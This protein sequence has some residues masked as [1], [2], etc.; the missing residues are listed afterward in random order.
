MALQQEK[1]TAI[2]LRGGALV[3]QVA[4][5]GAAEIGKPYAFKLVTGEQMVRLYYPVAKF[6]IYPKVTQQPQ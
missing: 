2:Q 6:Y 3:T 4:T 5:E 1:I